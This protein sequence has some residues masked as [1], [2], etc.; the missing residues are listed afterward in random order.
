MS[1][2][3]RI[4]HDDGS[5]SFVA[6]LDAADALRAHPD[7]LDTLETAMRGAV[8]DITGEDHSPPRA[9]GWRRLWFTLLGLVKVLVGVG[10]ALATLFVLF[11]VVL[12]LSTA[13]LSVIVSV[14][15]AGWGLL[16]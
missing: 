3:G 13:A 12:F 5:V 4:S 7:V 16:R 6:T 2:V 15:E 8:E 11:L 10:G 1:D 14:V 9:R